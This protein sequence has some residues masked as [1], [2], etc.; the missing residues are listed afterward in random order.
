MTHGSC[1]IR[2][3]READRPLSLLLNVRKRDGGIRS[4]PTCF[5]HKGPGFNGFGLCHYDDPAHNAPVGRVLRR[6][7]R[8]PAASGLVL[9][10]VRR[11]RSCSRVQSGSYARP[12]ADR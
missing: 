9:H 8:W 2:A 3:G 12:A 7:K 1:A 5:E 6:G 4:V 10:L 11:G